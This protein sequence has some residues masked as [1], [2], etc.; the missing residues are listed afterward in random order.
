MNRS[1]IKITFVLIAIPSAMVFAQATVIP[2][3]CNTS[4]FLQNPLCPCQDFQCVAVKIV[5]FLLEIAV[6]LTAI[7]VLVGGFIMITSA[8]NPEK[9]S[10][11][12]KTLLYAAIGFVVVLFANAIVQVIKSIF[13]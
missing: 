6:P 11:G 7:M 10:Q 8:G 1:V 2:S 13:Q 9:F 12:K 3:G 5:G 4:G